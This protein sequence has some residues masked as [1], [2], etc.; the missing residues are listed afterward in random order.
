MIPALALQA[1][2]EAAK[3][4]A[5][6]RLPLW[7]KLALSDPVFLV[8][9]PLVVL[10]LALGTPRR[11]QAPARVPS[12]PVIARRSAAQRLAWLP[13]L[14]QLASLV[15]VVLALA[16]PLRG[17]VEIAST[18]EG[19][20]IALLLD[21]SSSMDSRASRSA[22]TR[23]EIVKEVVGDFARRRMTDREGAADNVAL[24]AF[25]LY[26]ELLCPFTLD[27]DALE[28]VLADIDTE[29]R[30]ELDATGIGIALAKAVAVLRE[31]E[32]AS[33][34]VVLL[35]DG[36]ENVEAI[37][38]LDA[39]RV[40]AEEGIRIY[41]VF[42][43]PR[44]EVRSFFGQREQIPIDTREL[45]AIAET[46]GGRFY[47]A[48]SREDLEAVYAEIESLERT[49][50]EHRRYAEHFDLYPR[51]LAPALLCYLLYWLSVATWARRLP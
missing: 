51:L 22:P 31:S 45:E 11:R 6:V 49:E 50:R 21:R 24:I 19:V 25:A 15:L 10:A 46:T 48:E 1:T 47:H 40:A 2:L 34:I 9:L 5:E 42:A 14:L 38:P 16:R 28:G 30:R 41:T 13:R 17:D 20:D 44:Y 39:A 18:S 29:K 35:T 26:P 7:G 37:Q 43:G 23:F 33:R 4:A 12:L 27:V 8:C 32:A 36:M 3:S